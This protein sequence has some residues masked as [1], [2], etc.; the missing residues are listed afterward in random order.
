MPNK[1]QLIEFFVTFF[2]V[3]KIKYCPG[4][5]GS[6]AAFPVCYLIVYFTVTY[7]IIFPFSNLTLAE[8]QF[9]TFSIIALIICCILFIIGAYLSSSYM[10]Y[11]MRED[12]KEIVIDEVVGQLLVVLLSFFSVVFVNHSA[13]TKY[14]SPQ[15]IDIIFIFI[16]PFSL[17]RFFDILKPWPI[18]WLDKNIKSGVGV[19]FDDVVAAIFAAVV[20]YAITFSLIDWL[21]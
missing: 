10:K 8:A 12:P 15:A 7:Q 18:N 6:L 3:G 13:L 1:N 20:H 11:T 19:M 4:T 14:L 21:A 9:A 5:F 16:L 2:Y 17:F